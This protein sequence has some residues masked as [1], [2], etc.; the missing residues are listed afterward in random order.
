M[1]RRADKVSAERLLALLS[2]LG[3]EI[4]L[5]EVR[6]PLPREASNGPQW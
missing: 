5:R 2:M 3:A 1:E 4:V 6:Q